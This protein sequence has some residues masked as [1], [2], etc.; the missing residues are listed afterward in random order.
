MVDS[1]HGPETT[2][3]PKHEAPRGEDLQAWDQQALDENGSKL[4]LIPRRQSTRSR[5]RLQGRIGSLFRGE[6]VASLGSLTQLAVLITSGSLSSNAVLCTLGSLSYY[7][8]VAVFGSLFK[9]AVLRLYGSL[10]ND[11]VL[12]C[13]G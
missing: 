11:A 10:P 4:S 8:V 12:E 6:V 13:C 2:R 9:I 3:P 5:I 1:S 7:A